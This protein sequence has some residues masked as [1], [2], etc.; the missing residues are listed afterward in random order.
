MRTWF[1]K[2]EKQQEDPAALRCR[3]G[4]HERSAIRTEGRDLVST[5]SS[6]G[7]KLVR[8]GNEWRVAIVDGG[9]GEAARRSG[10]PANA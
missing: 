8:V 1:G 2:A 9:G 4:L 7:R 5:C 6:C 3:M 10:G